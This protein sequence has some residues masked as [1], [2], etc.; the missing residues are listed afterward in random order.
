MAQT[1]LVVGSGFAGLWGALA[2]A[3]VVDE[4]QAE[5]VNIV[6]AAPQP[7]LAMRPRLHE[8]DPAAWR[9]DILPHLDAAG[10]RY[11]QGA[12]QRIHRQ[13]GHVELIGAGGEP[14]SLAY[15]RLVLAAGS[16][17][18]RP[19]VPGLA[20]YAH[21][22]DQP[23]DAQALDAHFT[24]LAGLPA[25]AARDTVVVVGA[26]FTGIELACELPARLRARWPGAQ[27]RIVLVEQA[28]QVGPEL[29]AGPR[30]VIEQA[31]DC[32]GIERILGQAVASLDGGG[33][34]LAGGARIDAATVVWTGGM[35][36][37]SLAGQVANQVDALGRAVVA[38]DLRVDGARHIF[39]AGDAASARTDEQGHTTL[40]AC[41][42]ALVTGRY[43]G[44]NAARDLLGLA[45]Q[46][47]R[48][49]SYVTCLDLGAWGAVFTQGWQRNVSMAGADAK[50][51]KNQIN[52]EWIYPPA[53]QRT[54]LLAAAHPDRAFG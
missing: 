22:I 25:S 31:L 32:L 19:A 33:V 43:A 51:L 14:L 20:Q 42:H 38:D 18:H 8:A 52:R 44:H 54:L 15:D 39:A 5:G 41:Q 12:V 53:P 2:A 46:A 3:R 47:Y 11:V 9:T 28:G 1:I 7:Q 23:A 10:I 40:M 13:D 29:G 37:T 45:T 24:A 26:G 49:P 50:T 48:Q 30:P 27:P 4:Q 17:M 34:V 6:L 35:R 21:C 36:A 16:A